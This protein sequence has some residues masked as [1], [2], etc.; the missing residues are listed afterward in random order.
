VN[1][2]EW[3]TTAV[4]WLQARRPHVA[5]IAGL[6]LLAFVQRPGAVTFDTKLDLTEDPWGFLGRALSLWNPQ[7]SFGELQNQAYG[8]LFPIGPFFAVGNALAV[9]PWV[10][11]RM[12]T[13]L[14]LVLAY[15]GV[16]A[17]CRALPIGPR[18]AGIIGG[19]AYA[20]SPRMMTTIGPISSEALIVALLPW[21]VVPL[22]RWRAW[23]LRRAAALSGLAVLSMGGVNGT[24]T[25]AVLLLPALIIL[26][27]S[28]AIR[29]RLLGWWVISV[30]L[31]CAWWASAL[32]LLGRYSP[33]FLDYI[34]SA[35]NTTGRIG[36]FAALRG[37]THWVARLTIGREPWWPAGHEIAWTPLLI[38]ATMVI[39]V[40]GLVALLD[41]R[42]PC[43]TAFLWSAVL[44]LVVLTA[45]W[46]GPLG[47]PLAAVWHDWLDGSLAPLR[48]VHKFDPLVRLPVAIGLAH[49][50]GLLV[51]WRSDRARV[52]RRV[53]QRLSI[54][55][56]A[57]CALA[58][59][60]TALNPG[61]RPGP[62]WEEIP[63]WW[64][65]A[66]EFVADRDAHARTLVLPAAGFGTQV[67]GRTI[68]EPI[69]PL[70]D[71]PWV[72]RNQVLLGSEGAARLLEGLDR[73]LESGRG[74]PALGDAL[75]RAGIRFVIL[76]GDLDRRLAGTPPVAVIRQALERSAGVS[77]V[78]SF[79][80]ALRG[81]S[82][83][84]LRVSGFAMDASL[85]AIDVFEVEQAVPRVRLAAMDGVAGVTGGPESIPRLIE[86]GLLGPDQAAV[87]AID[88]PDSVSSWFVTDDLARRERSFGRIRDNLGPVMTA[89]EPTRQTRAA[90]DVLPPGAEAHQTVARYTGIAGVVASSSRGYPDAISR[91][92]TA[93]GPWSAL[94]GDPYTAWRSASSGDPVGE[95]LHVDLHTATDVSRVTVRFAAS[96]FGTRVTAVDV[97]TENGIARTAVRGDGMPE[98]LAV[99]AGETAFLRIEVA[100]VSDPGTGDVGI[101]DLRIPGVEPRRIVS[102]PDDRPQDT[103]PAGAEHGI[104][105]RRLDATRGACVVVG[106]ST[107]C[108]PNLPIRGDEPTSLIRAFTT[109]GTA[110]YH[111]SGTVLPRPGETAQ[112]YLEP[113]GG[114]TARASSTLASDPAVAAQRAVDFND[115]TSWVAD[116]FDPFPTIEISWAE[117]RLVSG[118]R[119]VSAEHPVAAR[120]LSVE[121]E[122]GGIRRQ[123]DV[124]DGWV[125]FP[126]LRTGHLTIT[127]TRWS[128]SRSVD[129]VTG[130]EIQAPPGI[131]EI[132]VPGTGDLIVAPDYDG[133][134]GRVCGLGPTVVLDGVELSTRVD[135]TYRDIAESRP[136]R[137]RVCGRSGWQIDLGPG[138][139]VMEIQ[140][141]AAFTVDTAVLRRLDASASEPGRVG[142]ATVRQWDQT[143]R[144]VDVR[145]AE[146]ALLVVPENYNRG[147]VA[148]AGGSELRSLRVDGWQQGWVLPESYDG[149][150]N[151]VFT[152]QRTFTLGLGAGLLGVVVLLGLALVRP[153]RQG[154]NTR[155]Y[156]AAEADLPGS[157]SRLWAWAAGIAAGAAVLAMA[158]SLAIPA[159]AAGYVRN[160]A[161]LTALGMVA[162]GAV[163]TVYRRRIRWQRPR[164][165]VSLAYALIAVQLA[166]RAWG[167]SRSYFWLDDYVYFFD[168]GQPLSLGYLFQDYKGHLMPGQFLLVWLLN[169]VAPLAWLPAASLVIGLQLIASLLVLRLLRSMVGDGPL[170]FVIFAVYA[171]SP[172]VFAATMWWASALQALPLQICM[173]WALLAHLRYLR[174]GSWRAVAATVAAVV[175]GFLFW[176]KAL[177]IGPML[178]AFTVLLG[179]HVTGRPVLEIARK[180]RW[181]LAGYLALTV[182]LTALLLTLTDQERGPVAAPA[183]SG[184]LLRI[185]I[186]ETFVPALSGTMVGGEAAGPL[187]APTPPWAVVLVSWQ[188][189]A[190]LIVGTIIVARWAAAAGWL[191]ILGYLLVDVG[192]VA[193]SRIDFVGP[194][195]G[196]DPRYVAD[197]LV[198]TVVGVAAI[199]AAVRARRD[200]LPDPVWQGR[201][202]VAFVGVAAMVN[203]SLI[204]T[205]DVASDLPMNH[206]RNYAA[207]VKEAAGR[208]GGVD[209]VDGP[210]PEFVLAEFF[211][212]E[213]TARVAVGPLPER[214]RFYQPTHDLRMLDGLG[215][216]RPIQITV[217]AAADPDEEAECA[218]P[219]GSG[220]V[221][222]PL[223]A[224]LG[225]AKWVVRVGYVNGIAT[226]GNLIVG[227][228]T[229]D[230]DLREGVHHLFVELHEPVAL[231][232]VTL[233]G[234]PRGDGVCITD[235]V[236]GT[237]WPKPDQP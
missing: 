207:T 212:A 22:L 159:G 34:E 105:F 35:E 88:S 162:I 185:A 143:D 89:D 184:A 209:L 58:P 230:V 208:P 188:V 213:A 169:Q 75:S 14:I 52:A 152:P 94:D 28:R 26:A 100:E 77:R 142:S 146:P 39:G 59:L 54:A 56:L 86:D 10:L 180:T 234:L 49:L 36:P 62:G 38:T 45:G 200:L 177:L 104:S 128:G 157:A 202:L 43:R 27:Q 29:L 223:S 6:V 44:G 191:F 174:T 194:L 80:P 3:P 64:R 155:A 37:D 199:G 190:V 41:R 51:S 132:E 73:W 63:Q 231:D 74:S 232:S 124:E 70:A 65:D 210:V 8:Y 19:L 106:F 117:R 206:G 216:A 98:T 110:T 181:A 18:W 186:V 175:V 103:Q 30:G 187:L 72:S 192:L 21:V 160:A 197:A 121:V 134:T 154:G 140:A 33:R 156:T 101:V 235:V 123:L 166:W 126:S 115:A 78:A 24:A 119:L 189:L 147:W 114:V 91:T 61:L 193:T 48:N 139:H 53:L 97:H 112:R 167:L 81:G 127:I 111:L 151:L 144:V 92:D 116:P 171:V 133:P 218:W 217:A 118:F 113:L 182:A 83:A 32:I 201:Q 69:Q 16:V 31:A 196:R 93:L 236:V 150:V 42:V 122:A 71:A 145:T 224:D 130:H 17:V 203:L 141:D 40:V 221:T 99:P 129:P 135:G 50:V 87:L 95:W 11:Q 228:R 79:G 165:W 158:V 15:V 102:A 237:A 55:V 214:P 125:R 66:A 183:E 229:Y 67:W 2:R 138:H 172:I 90:S 215:R 136:L 107:R 211:G 148:H 109:H 225:A 219:I 195:I 120:P 204:S 57:A 173:T 76:R 7:S 84:G 1:A 205:Y 226:S 233:G 47:S 220:Q 20:L 23:G 149:E 131:A 60:L 108:D 85:P 12:W 164:V 4:T 168:A 46:T 82:A 96:V 222:I 227:D 153:R 68:D 198:V 13:S 9:P 176:Q 137:W 5:V 25:I 163:G 178:V 170:G 179:S 161:A